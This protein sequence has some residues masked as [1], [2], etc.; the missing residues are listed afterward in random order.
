[1]HQSEVALQNNTFSRMNTAK[2]QMLET[3]NK[4]SGLKKSNSFISKPLTSIAKDKN[5][6]PA[7]E[8]KPVKLTNIQSVIEA[9]EIEEF[10]EEEL[11]FYDKFGYDEILNQTGI[12]N[13]TIT[14]EDSQDE[15][16]QNSSMRY[17]STANSTVK[18]TSKDLN[19]KALNVDISLPIYEPTEKV[20]E[21]CFPQEEGSALLKDLDLNSMKAD[22]TLN[23][24]LNK[25]VGSFFSDV[26]SKVN[27]GLK[28]SRVGQSIR[29]PKLLEDKTNK[30]S[31]F[32]EQK[33]STTIDHR[34]LIESKRTSL[35]T[36]A[37]STIHNSDKKTLRKATTMTLP[38][39]PK[40]NSSNRLKLTQS[41]VN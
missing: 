34:S 29:Q 16:M 12:F 39:S 37:I 21:A 14:E 31:S 30:V 35:P 25:G 9:T 7:V 4:S 41:L 11:A 19:T 26:K 15:S 33:F 2:E 13:K 6:K 8:F 1:M 24:T 32:E 10:T 3:L 20:E 18:S 36:R 22:S 40:F 28:R 27:T 17:E 38:E 5:A 23:R